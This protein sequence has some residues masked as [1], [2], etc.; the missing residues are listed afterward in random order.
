M[1]MIKQGCYFVISTIVLLMMLVLTAHL[2]L[3]SKNIDKQSH[4]YTRLTEIERSSVYAHMSDKAISQ[5]LEELW[6]PG[7][8]YE[9][10]TG[11]SEVE[12]SGEFV[13]VNASG[14]RET[15]MPNDSDIWFFG[16]STSF[17]YGVADWE[18]IPSLV[19]EQLNQKVYNFARGWYYSEQENVLLSKLLVAGKK[20]KL[21]VF[22]DGINERCDI[23]AYQD[24]LTLL[25]QKASK[26][27]AWGYQ[28]FLYP[29]I[30]LSNNINLNFT[31]QSSKKD[32]MFPDTCHRFDV[33]Y[34]LGDAFKRN[35]A[36]RKAI[37]TE[38]GI[39]CI[40]FLQPFA[41]VDGIHLNHEVL[42]DDARKRLQRK[43]ENLRMALN[44]D[45][46]IDISDALDGL[47]KHAYVDS[48]HYGF[49]ANQLI[50]NRIASQ[51]NRSS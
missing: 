17:G 44:E 4:R 10:Y 13:T 8:Q 41:G 35:L 1:N 16:G 48:V 47:S 23:S 49:E 31:S 25:F 51:I 11:F 40:T 45:D 6:A 34:P 28:D 18:T 29:I 50:A 22:V 38:A 21:A 2:I 39:E 42:T 14:F 9:S 27:Y 20:P 36:L 7:F 32:Q 37:C 46:I 30:Y 26:N 43:K 19:Q 12:R 33:S 24:E 15:G 3:K 5:M